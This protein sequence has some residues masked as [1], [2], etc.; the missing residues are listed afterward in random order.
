MKKVRI[1]EG[2]KFRKGRHCMRC[3][4]TRKDTREVDCYARI[5]E[6]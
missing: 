4:M 1:A 5:E 6:A 3:G 2:G